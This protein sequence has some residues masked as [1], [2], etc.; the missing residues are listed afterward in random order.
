MTLDM[1][2]VLCIVWHGLFSLSQSALVD[3]CLLL[4]LG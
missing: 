1:V 4:S 2:F 3:H